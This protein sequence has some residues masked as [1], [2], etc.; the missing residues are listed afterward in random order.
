MD[1]FN[2]KMDGDTFPFHIAIAVDSDFPRSEIAAEKSEDRF[3]VFERWLLSNGA[4]FPKLEL[5]KQGSD[6]MRGCHSVK[7]GGVW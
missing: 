6:E 5:K 4:K 1:C 3:G 2:Q 7:V